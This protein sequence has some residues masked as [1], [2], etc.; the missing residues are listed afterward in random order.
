MHLYNFRQYSWS[1]SVDRTRSQ[2]KVN[3]AENYYI[4]FY[5]LL[6][7]FL[8]LLQYYHVQQLKS[9]AHSLSSIVH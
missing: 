2:I 8:G 1:I 3:N 5:R 4:C 9:K 7:F 6:F